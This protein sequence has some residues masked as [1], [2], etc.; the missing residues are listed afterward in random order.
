[1]RA[2]VCLDW[3]VKLC[4]SVRAVVVPTFVVLCGLGL[5]SCTPNMWLG[6]M[7][8]REHGG[9]FCPRLDILVN[10]LWGASL[11]GNLASYGLYANVFSQGWVGILMS[12]DN[13]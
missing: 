10:A 13:I 4:R 3:G 11:N 7:Y 5:V 6:K 9:P 1:M 8:F 12:L 2:Y